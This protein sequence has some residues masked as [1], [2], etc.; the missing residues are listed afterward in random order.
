MNRDENKN[1]EM[2]GG[3]LSAE[4]EAR[5]TIGQMAHMNGVSEKTLRL[6]HKQGLLVPAFVD[7]ENGYR[8]YSIFQ[9]DQLDMIGQMK[10]IGFSLEEIKSILVEEDVHYLDQLLEENMKRLDREITQLTIARQMALN[11]K[12][13]C[14]LML[15]KPVCETITV[16]HF[17]RRTYL[18]LPIEGY[19]PGE[20]RSPYEESQYHWELSLRQVKKE[21]LKRKLPLSMFRNVGCV[22]K[23]EDLE[24]G[25]I[26]FSE[27]FL[28]V[29][30]GFRHPGCELGVAEE[31]DYLCVVCDG[32]RTETAEHKED[33]YLRRILDR[34]AGQGYQITGNYMGEILLDTPAFQYKNRDSLLRIQVPI[35]PEDARI[36]RERIAKEGAG[37]LRG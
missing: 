29:Q 5:L 21:L 23:K 24:K 32:V 36:E 15:N 16:E 35:A 2:A 19:G 13:S 9:S 33:V 28:W 7:E 26:F 34:I 8:Y 14:Q 17:P 12:D 10:A 37:W 3:G 30:E 18:R 20:R 22:V 31:G 27:A 11:L 4:A 6:Y 1:P 25:C